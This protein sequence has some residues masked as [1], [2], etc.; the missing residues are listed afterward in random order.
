MIELK[1]VSWSKFDKN[2]GTGMYIY[3]IYIYI[4][5]F[6]LSLGFCL[7]RVENVKNM[8]SRNGGSMVTYGTKYKVKDHL[9]QTKTT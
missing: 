5:F 9:G 1:K 7:R 8:F 2:N 4:F 6:I 3:L